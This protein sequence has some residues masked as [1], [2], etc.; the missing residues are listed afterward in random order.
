V[1]DE[2]AA[3]VLAEVVTA[4]GRRAG[5]VAWSLSHR[6]DAHDVSVARWFETYR[7]TEHLPGI[8]GL[9]PDTAAELAAILRG[10]QVQAVLHELLA[11]RLTDAPETDVNRIRSLF[12]L[13]FD[14]AGTGTA[15]YETTLFDYYD[16]EICALTARLE[17]TEPG[18]LPRSGRKPSVPGWSPSCTRSSGIPPRPRTPRTRPI[19]GPRRTS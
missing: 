8:A 15:Q 2:V 17:G 3:E 18:L 11:A 1:I 12:R 19:L 13:A 4:V 5:T 7:L 6:R 16:G 10:D 14:A 9:T